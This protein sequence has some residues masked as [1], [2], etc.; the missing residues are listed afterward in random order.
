MNTFTYVLVASVLLTG[1][2]N[3]DKNDT[4]DSI[5]TADNKI[6]QN[7]I[8]KANTKDIKPLEIGVSECD[9]YFKNMKL[10]IEKISP[11][12]AEQSLK[13]LKSTE[14]QWQAIPKELVKEQ[15]IKATEAAKA[16]LEAKGCSF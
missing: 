6:V 8:N 1:C 4:V 16:S 10:C 11:N 2:F 15:C 12:T 14:E 3:K 5:N 9:N 13:A 7:D